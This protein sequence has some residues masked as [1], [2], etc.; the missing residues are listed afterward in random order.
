MKMRWKD[1][2]YF[3]RG[4]RLGVLF[5]LILIMLTF[6]MQILVTQRRSS[7]FVLQQNDSLV[8]A[9]EEFRRNGVFN[10]PDTADYTDRV[11]TRLKASQKKKSVQSIERDVVKP[12]YSVV[13]KLNAGEVISLNESDTCKWKMIPGIGSSY[14]QRI[15]KY[16]ELLGGYVSKNQLLEVYGLEEDLFMRISPY[17]EADTLCRQ[18]QVNYAEF[19]ELLRHPYLNYEQVKAIVNLRDKKGNIQSIRELAMLDI[20]TKDDIKRLQPYLAF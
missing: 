9:F 15:V 16:R 11:I 14:A 6:I 12:S 3:N 10:A 20:F 7:L 17:I 13:K 19:R 2:F 18:L 5:L 8:Q 4:T 1:F